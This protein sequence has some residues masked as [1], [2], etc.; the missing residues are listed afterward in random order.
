MF[1][2]NRIYRLFQ[3]INYLKARPAKSVRSIE[4]FLETSERTAYRY[5]DLLKDLGF[6]IEKDS[7]NKLFIAATSEL[8]HIPFTPQEA[9]Y[10]K[11]LILSAGKEN[12][13]AQSVLQKIQQS[14]EIELGAD[15]LFKAHLAKIVEQISVAIIEGKQLLIKGYSSANSQSVTDRL[16]EPTCFTENYDSVSA[17]EIK[18]RLNK[19]FNIERMTSVEV[20]EKPMKYEDQ[21]EFYKPDIFGFQGKSMNKEIEL[22]MSMRAYLLLKEEYPMSAAFIKPI[23]D[24][25][26]YYF[27]ANVQSFQAPGRFVMGFLEEV[28]V[29]GSKEFIRFIQ[30]VVKKNN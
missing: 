28:Q 13:L 7:K 9:D 29:L 2:Q 21:H 30:K 26:K 17:F 15:S 12:Q 18:T 8:E 24:T 25:G 27:K 16:V 5:L 3:L 4:A 1:N 6:Q 22:E 14:S 23:P 19:Y 11:K 10:L 20:L